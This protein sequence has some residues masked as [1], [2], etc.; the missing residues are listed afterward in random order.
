[1]DFHKDSTLTYLQGLSE[2]RKCTVGVLFL[3]N[4]N[5]VFVQVIPSIISTPFFSQRKQVQSGITAYRRSML[6]A[7]LNKGN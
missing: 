5:E 4:P 6:K 1:M 2:H 3:V 7:S